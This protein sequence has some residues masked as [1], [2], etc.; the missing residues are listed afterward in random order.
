M[1]GFQAFLSKTGSSKHN[2]LQFL[3]FYAVSLRSFRIKVEN[4][5]RKMLVEVSLFS[6]FYS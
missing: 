6:L 5:E 4:P 3:Q 2:V 1:N